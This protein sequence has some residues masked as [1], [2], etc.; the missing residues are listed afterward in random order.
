MAISDWPALERPRDVMQHRIETAKNLL[1]VTDLTLSEV[2]I[3][4]GF[5]DASDLGK[6]FRKY[7]GITPKGYRQRLRHTT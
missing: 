7:E 4:S 5:Y 2:A 3:Q 6:R 1:A